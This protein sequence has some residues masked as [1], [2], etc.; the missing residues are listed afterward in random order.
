MPKSAKTHEIQVNPGEASKTFAKA[1]KSSKIQ[2][3]IQLN[4]RKSQQIQLNDL[5][6]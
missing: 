5:P 3:K 1:S 4:L 6:G 2:V